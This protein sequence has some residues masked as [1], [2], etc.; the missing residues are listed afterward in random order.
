VSGVDSVTALLAVLEAPVSPRATFGEE[1]KSRLLAELEPAAVLEARV[2]RTPGSISARA[3]ERRRRSRLRVALVSVVLLLFLASA[4]AAAFLAL[5]ETRGGPTLID[6]PS[7]RA[8]S[9]SGID[10]DGQ[11]QKIWSCPHDEWCGD[12]QNVAWAPDGKRIAISLTEFGGRSLYPGLH[13]V[14]SATGRDTQV[15][16]VPGLPSGTAPPTPRQK[17]LLARARRTY[18]RFGCISPDEMAW[19]P[20][21]SKIAYVCPRAGSSGT[22]IHIMDADGTHPRLLHTRTRGAAWPSWSP[23]GDR[24]AFSTAS[25]PRTKVGSGSFTWA[26]SATSTIYTVHLDG[27]DRRRVASGAAPAWSADGSTIAYRSTCGGKVRLVRPDGS[28]ATPAGA[29]ARCSGIGPAGWP[30]WS[31]DGTKLAIGTDKDVYL[32]D[33]DGTHLE[34]VGRAS[35]AYGIGSLRPVWQPLPRASS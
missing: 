13:I 5:S 1:L 3:P 34:R 33:L 18:V 16:G 12:V 2:A 7:N 32:I 11:A 31:P 27:S 8:A 20:D 26:R 21:G 28:D 30:A 35:P 6:T 22:A 14:D 15:I 17:A 24:I 19:S 9:I 23:A 29:P 10:A 4:A 25:T